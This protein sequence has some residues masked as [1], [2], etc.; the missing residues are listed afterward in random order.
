[1]SHWYL[2]P[3]GSMRMSLEHRWRPWRRANVCERVWGR[4]PSCL[5]IW[6]SDSQV[7]PPVC[8]RVC[9]RPPSC[10][11][12]WKSDCQA[13]PKKPHIY[14][15]CDWSE[16]AMD[17]EGVVDSEGDKQGAHRIALGQDNCPWL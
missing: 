17:S 9:W 2:H 11:R 15:N 14:Q 3:N 7:P 12:I 10:L 8:E 13:P 4:P 16:G 1:M 5:Q 6:K